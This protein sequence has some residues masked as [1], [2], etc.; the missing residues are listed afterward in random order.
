MKSWKKWLT[1]LL[2]VACISAMAVG[3]TACGGGNAGNSSPVSEEESDSEEE[4]VQE[5][6]S[7]TVKDDSNNPLAN[8]QIT[9]KKGNKTV[10]TITTDAN[11]TASVQLELGVYTFNLKSDS[12][13]AGFIP[14]SYTQSVTLVESCS[15]IFEVEDMNP[16][17]TMAKPFACY[18]DEE[19]K[20]EATIPAG[21]EYFY[22]ASKISGQK[23]TISQ[24]GIEVKF[25]NNTY[26]TAS[27]AIEVP[28]GEGI[29]DTNSVVRF[30]IK[31]VT[32]QDA[33]F[34]ILFSTI[35]TATQ[36]DLVIGE[37]TAT[38]N[39]KTVEFNWTATANGVLTVVCTNQ[40][41]EISINNGN[42]TETLDNTSKE[43]TVTAGA[44]IKI[45]VTQKV[46]VEQTVET[47]TFTVTFA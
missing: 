8:A 13:P 1:A 44:I 37:N 5:T 27:G 4:V 32:T 29:T 42:V 11:G 26:S 36:K 19:G 41:V 34:D 24:P 16:N 28:L 40:D 10:T 9:V 46:G 33:T 23:I 14:D 35:I 2:S 25:D 15:I 20:F 3:L 18:S 47:V 31:N 12:L 45:I 39:G 17:G 43:I 22:T 6:V 30:S 38:L 7:V 21:V